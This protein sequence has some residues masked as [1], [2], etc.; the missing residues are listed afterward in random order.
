MFCRAPVPL[1]PLDQTLTPSPQLRRV[2][3]PPTWSRN[4][5]AESSILTDMDT[6]LDNMLTFGEEVLIEAVKYK[7]V[8]VV[9]SVTR[10]SSRPDP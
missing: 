7:P 2:D 5:E 3:R 1:A 9:A 8:S 4:D 6:F 10:N